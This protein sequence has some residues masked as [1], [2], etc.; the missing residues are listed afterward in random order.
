MSE[1]IPLKAE[2]ELRCERRGRFLEALD[3][4]IQC[5]IESSDG[6]MEEGEYER[7]PTAL[8]DAWEKLS[9]ALTDLLEH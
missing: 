3:N 4:Y 2:G 5:R 1:R 8:G 9:R 6:A 7:R